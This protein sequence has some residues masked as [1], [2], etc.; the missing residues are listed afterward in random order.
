MKKAEKSMRKYNNLNIGMFMLLNIIAC[1]GL[2]SFASL[3]YITSFAKP[4]NHAGTEW[5]QFRLI[6]SYDVITFMHDVLRN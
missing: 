2:I 3:A 4:I 1:L 6:L 5:K